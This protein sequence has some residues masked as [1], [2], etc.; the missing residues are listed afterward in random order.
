[1][2]IL[3]YRTALH[4]RRWWQHWK[5]ILVV[6]SA[7]NGWLHHSCS[8][9]TDTAHVLSVSRSKSVHSAEH[10]SLQPPTECWNE[11]FT[12]FPSHVCM[13]VPAALT[14]VRGTDSHQAHFCVFRPIKCPLG[15]TGSCPWSGTVKEWLDHEHEDSPT[16]VLGSG[17]SRIIYKSMLITPPCGKVFKIRGEDNHF[18]L[19]TRNKSGIL[20]LTIRLVLTIK[21]TKGYFFHFMFFLEGKEQLLFEYFLKPSVFKDNQ[22]E[23]DDC[24]RMDVVTSHG[25]HPTLYALLGVQTTSLEQWFRLSK[26]PLKYQFGLSCA[27]NLNK[28]RVTP[29]YK[30]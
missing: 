23:Y 18:I 13:R 3:F 21:P 5:M 15:I 10:P 6:L 24:K 17:C 22:D 19:S 16:L 28:K 12:Y 1:M 4:S 27:I 29:K 20:S 11:S 25:T 30:A 9:A 8:V 26:T 2:S 14:L 7:W